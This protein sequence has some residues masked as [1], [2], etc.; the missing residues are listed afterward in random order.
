MTFSTT[1]TIDPDIIDKARDL[2][3]LLSLAVP[4]S[5]V[6]KTKNAPSFCYCFLSATLEQFYKFNLFELV[7]HFESHSFSIDFLC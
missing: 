4:A 5:M 2:L 3:Q 1:R 7:A 6:K